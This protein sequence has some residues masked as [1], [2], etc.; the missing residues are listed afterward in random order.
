MEWKAP[1]R[2]AIMKAATGRLE[3]VNATEGLVG[4][5]TGWPLP[6]RRTEVHETFLR[7]RNKPQSLHWGPSLPD[8][9][10]EGQPL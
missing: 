5:A 7:V 6:V 3:V 2:V 8:F 10:D 4:S 1:R 9:V